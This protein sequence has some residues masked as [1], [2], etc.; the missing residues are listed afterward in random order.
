MGSAKASENQ[1]ADRDNEKDKN[2]EF[3][4]V[5]IFVRAANVY[6]EIGRDD[7]GNGRN[8]GTDPYEKGKW[9]QYLQKSRCSC[10]E[11]NAPPRAQNNI[12]IIVSRTDAIA[13]LFGQP[14]S[15]PT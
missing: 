1:N 9:D 15:K 7:S 4:V 5:R 8:I 10:V 13:L 11:H 6:G 14:P 12:I 3:R 2:F